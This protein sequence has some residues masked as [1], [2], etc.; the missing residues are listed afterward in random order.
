MQFLDD[1]CKRFVDCV[2]DWVGIGG[3][4]CGSMY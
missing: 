1:G 2:C 4:W 3:G